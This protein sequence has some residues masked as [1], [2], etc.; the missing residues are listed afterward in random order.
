ME[1]STNIVVPP[2]VAAI[3]ADILKTGGVAPSAMGNDVGGIPGGGINAQGQQLNSVGNPIGVANIRDITTPVSIP[4]T[5]PSTTADGI[6]GT[7]QSI[8][9]QIAT[10]NT[11]DLNTAQGDAANSKGVLQGLYD[12]IT[13]VQAS[14]ADEETQAGIPQKT[15][16]LTDAQN[17]LNA[18]KAAR[19][20]EL[21]ALQGQ[22]LTDVQK[23]QQAAEINRK[24]AAADVTLGVALSAA[25][26]N[27]TTA[28]NLVDR[29]IQ[30]ELEPL[31]TQLEEAKQFYADNKATLDKEQTSAL[32]N[33]IK[34]LDSQLTDLKEGQKEVADYTKSLID[35]GKATPGLLQQLDGAKNGQEAAAILTQNGVNLVKPSTSTAT[36]D[37]SVTVT[38]VNGQPIT[39]PSIVSPYYNVS[40]SGVGYIDASTLQGTAKDKTA[41]VRAATQAGLKVIT[42]KNQAADLSNINDAYNKLDTIQNTIGNL[43]QPNALS[44]TLYGAGLTKLATL[45]Q[46]DPQ[47]AAAGALQ[48]I[49][50][51]VL[52]AISGVQGFRG[53]QIA[54]Q[55]VTD[56]LPSIY[57]TKDVV[58]QKLDYIRQLVGDR[59][60]G[61]LGVKSSPSSTNT[62]ESNGK[63]WMVG[64]PY[65]DSSGAMWV[66]DAKGNWT[67]Q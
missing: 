51:D 15:Q 53:N 46:S 18:S 1:N 41:I 38:D 29:K 50:L 54:I 40:H 45:T 7:T 62:V 17:A 49:G 64:Q 52:K 9:D 47:K 25:Q 44:R 61:L 67:K 32:T 23:A 19:Q 2:R 11:A 10:A 55:Q 36:D 21:L 13:G 24:Y 12:K 66:V 65:Q 5:T 30:L 6:H 37:S 33:R 60:D 56:H 34:V 35:L 43:A 59:E 16:D 22:G 39:V 3:N 31:Q 8:L 20:S 14:R 27:L 28:K 4:S 48:S 26:G 42:N 63:T 57:D 58:A